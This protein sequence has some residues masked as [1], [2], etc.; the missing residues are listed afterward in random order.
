MFLRLIRS[1]IVAAALVAVA[2]PALANPIPTPPPSTTNTITKVGAG[3]GA[4]SG[5]VGAA[6]IVQYGI[7]NFAQNPIALPQDL[8]G[9]A[10]S[11]CAAA[12]VLGGGW[13]FCNSIQQWTQLFNELQ[14]A[15][16]QIQEMSA[17]VQRFATYPQSMQGYVQNDLNTVAALANNL[18]GLSFTDQQIAT[19]VGKIY[20]SNVPSTNYAAYIA[21]LQTSTKNSVVNALQVAGAEVSTQQR[22]SDTSTIIKTAL[23]NATSPT[24][25]VQA[26]AQLEAVLIEQIQKEQRLSAAAIQ[27][28]AAYYLAENSHKTTATQ[29]ETQAV[30]QLQHQLSLTFTSSPV[31][32]AQAAKMVSTSGPQVK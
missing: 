5:A 2:S 14:A 1:A 23:A 13:T 32:A 17:N 29:A 24:Q 25:S 3:A 9:F 7:A 16:N 4:V 26:L 27:S 19:T 15:K 22:D 28:S 21:Q 11:A 30:T 12:S 18:N 20:P 10:G 8:A 31:T 6:G